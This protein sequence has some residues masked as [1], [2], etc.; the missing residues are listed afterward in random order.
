[1][2]T[3]LGD[4]KIVIGAFH[5]QVLNVIASMRTLHTH[6]CV[7][8]REPPQ[9]LSPNGHFPN[10][11]SRTDQIGEDLVMHEDNDVADT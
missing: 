11:E 5:E 9:M 8:R 10:G 7:E 4:I 6:E 3:V 1:M 2:S